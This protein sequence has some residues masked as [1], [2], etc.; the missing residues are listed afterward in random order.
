MTTQ[1]WDLLGTATHQVLV[2]QPG[3]L[4][5]DAKFHL[6]LRGQQQRLGEGLLL[7]VHLLLQGLH[8]G[9]EALHLLLMGTALG[10]QL[11]LQQPAPGRGAQVTWGWVSAPE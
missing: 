6:G 1:S 11:G 4:L 8:L 9:L 2:G 7:P 10:L 3:H 5:L